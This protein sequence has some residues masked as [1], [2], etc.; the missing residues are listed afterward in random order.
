MTESSPDQQDALARALHPLGTVVRQRQPVAIR[1]AAGLMFAGAAALRWRDSGADR[2]DEYREI[3]GKR[4][5]LFHGC[6]SRLRWHPHDRRG[7]RPLGLDGVYGPGRPW[8]GADRVQRLFRRHVPA[9]HRLHPPFS[10]TCGRHQHRAFHRHRALFSALPLI[11]GALEW[12]V[13]L[14]AII[15]VWQRAAGQFY[16]ASGQARA[17]FREPRR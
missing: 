6:G 12:L 11:S 2:V 9:A 16:A 14:A 10:V 15:L 3:F 13:G 17:V 7:V 8:M 5:Q 4:R 1:W